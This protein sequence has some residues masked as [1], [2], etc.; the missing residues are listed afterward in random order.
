MSALPG[1]KALVFDVF[2]TVVDW[3]SGIAR[4][5]TAF[6]ARHGR[7]DVDPPAFA[8]AWRRRYQPA[9][10]EVRTG[11]RPFTRLDV[12]HRENLDGVLR[13]HGIDP[14][15][16]AAAELDWLNRAW[17][18]LDPWPDT[19][20]GL[21]RLKA[22]HF[23]APLSNGNILLLANMAKRAGMPW[24]AILGAEVARAYK[25]QPEAYLRTAEVLGLAPGEVALVAAHNGDLAAARKAGLKTAFVLRP[26]E[27]G[28]AQTTDTR[29]E[30]E[31]EAIASSFE[32]L[33][34]R[35]AC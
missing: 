29:A 27:H 22:R 17:H 1:V 19:I 34:D 2:G 10:E 26:T 32:D 20:P 31:W 6:L 4:D 12:L 25:P 16:I 35:L 8:D 9:M 14:A 5:A 3:R 15:G 11:R 28:P 23:I 7:S 24:D 33:A 21:I 30:A 18:R 13:D